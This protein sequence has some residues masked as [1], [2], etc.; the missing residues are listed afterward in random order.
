M[1]RKD[2]SPREYALTIERL[3]H[4]GRGVGHVE[5]KT[6]FVAD[7]LP[8]ERIQ[9]RVT[10]RHR[11]FDEAVTETLE[12]P[13]ADRVSPRCEHASLCGGCSLQHL[14]PAAQLAHKEAVLIELLKHQGNTRPVEILPPITGPLWAYRRRARLSVRMVHKKG[15]VLVGFREK[16]THYVTEVTHCAV[17]HP[18]VGERFPALRDLIDSLSIREQ[19]PQIEV[20]VDDDNALLAIRNMATPTEE[21]LRRLRAFETETGLHLYL[22]PGDPASCT[23]VSAPIELHYTMAGLR[24]GFRPGDFVQVNAAIN[25]Q[26]VAAAVRMLAPGADERVLDLFCGLGNFTLPLAATGATSVLGLEGEAAL[27]ERARE[28]A[29]ANGL[30]NVLFARAD[31][32][33]PEGVAQLAGRA[34]EKI[35]LDPPR[36][37]AEQVLQALNLGATRRLVYVSCN[38][39]TLA[40]DTAILV[41][42]RG[43]RLQSA[44]I[45]DMFPHTAHVESIALFEPRR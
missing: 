35:L 29:Q 10:R 26:L 16:A 12:N 32:F 20:A 25:A 38:P 9:A 7:A 14:A 36:S 6:V 37:G 19:I 34:F 43:F 4:E 42:D 27:V 31:L 22:Q 1:R 5:G 40:R 17:L 13:S 8:G 11:R 28:N 24:Y 33:T 23:P 45:V 15:H 39:V 21:D 3:S 18:A 2:N 30:S 41:R 44:G